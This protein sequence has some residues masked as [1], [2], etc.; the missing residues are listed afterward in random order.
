MMYLSWLVHG[1]PDAPPSD[2]EL[3]AAARAEVEPFQA[4]Q[5]WDGAIALLEARDAARAAKLSRNDWY[6]LSRALEIVAA[7]ERNGKHVVNSGDDSSSDSN[8]AQQY[9]MRCFFL[10]CHREQLNRRI[11]QR[12]ERMLKLGLLQE[13][14]ALLSTGA[15][16]RDSV[17]AKSIGYRQAVEFLTRPGHETDASH[18]ADDLTSNSEVCTVGHGKCDQQSEH[19]QA[20]EEAF[21]QFAVD[22]C[23]ASRRYAK[24]QMT[25]FRSDEIFCWVPTDR[26]YATATGGGDLG[27][28]AHGDFPSLEARVGQLLQ[29][30]AA[31]FAVL[32]S[33]EQQQRIREYNRLEGSKLKAYQPQ[34][35]MLGTR[36]STPAE[37][38]RKIL[39][40]L[41]RAARESRHRVMNA[42]RL[43]KA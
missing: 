43:W 35:D 8:R 5:D 22:F 31:E 38:Q 16:G 40:P 18:S 32:T 14:A 28:G 24:R 34:L 25:W 17:A 1:P 10:C 39:F 12:C 23:T 37:Q 9:D 2:P 42:R 26:A 36:P 21:H 19:G 6:R 27:D 29:M 4:A 13:T 33:S 11:D 15:L 7:R 3:K 30:S 41:L 20:E